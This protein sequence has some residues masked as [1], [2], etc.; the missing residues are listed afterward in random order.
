MTDIEFN[1]IVNEVVNTLKVNAKTIDQLTAKLELHPDSDWFE[2]NDGRKVSF[3]VL[4]ALIVASASDAASGLQNFLSRVVDDTANGHITFRQGLTSKSVAALERGANFGTFTSGLLGTGACINGLGDAEVNSLFSR[5]FISTPEFRFNRVAVTEG[6]LWNTNGFGEIIDVDYTNQIV[7]LKIEEG[8][9]ASIKEGDLC[10]GLYNMIGY[11]QENANRQKNYDVTQSAPDTNGFNRKPGFFTSYFWVKKLLTP[12]MAGVCKFEYETMSQQVSETDTTPHPCKNMKFAQYGNF[13]DVNRQSSMYI[14][15]LNGHSFI[16]QMEGVNTWVIGPANIA[17]RQGYLGNLTVTL[18]RADGTTYNKTLDGNGIFVKDNVYFGNALIHLDLESLEDIADRLGVYHAYLSA[19]TDVIKVDDVG[20]VIDGLWYTETIDGTSVNRYRIYTALTVRKGSELLQVAP[21]GQTLGRGYYRVT[22]IPHGCSCSFE[23]STLY[24]TGIDNVKDGVAGSSDDT[25]DAEDYAA[26]RAVERISVDLVIDCEGVGTIVQTVPVTIKHDPVPYIIADLTNENAA[27]SW[28]TNEAEYVGLPVTTKINMAKGNEDLDIEDFDINTINGVAPTWQQFIGQSNAGRKRT[29]T[30]WE[31]TMNLETGVFSV[32]DAPYDAP[33]VTEIVFTVSTHY[34]GSPYE[35]TLSLH[36]TRTADRAIWDI[37]PTHDGVNVDKNDH[38]NFSSVGVRVYSQS[39]EQGRQQAL[40]LPSGFAL[41]YAIT[42]VTSSVQNGETIYTTVTMP[43]VT[44]STLNDTVNLEDSNWRDTITNVTF[45]LYN[46]D[47]DIED[48]EGVSIVREGVGGQGSTGPAGNGVS[49]VTTYYRRS[50]LATGVTRTGTYTASQMDGDWSTA[51]V[52]PND[53]WP[54]VWSYTKYTYTKADPYYTPCVLVARYTEDGVG[55][56]DITHWYLNTSSGTGVTRPSNPLTAGWSQT[57]TPPSESLKYVWRFIDYTYSDG[58][59]AYSQCELIAIFVKDGQ[60]S[61]KS[62]VFKRYTPTTQKPKPDAPTTGSFGSPVPSGWTDGLPSG[63]EP[64]WMTSCIFTSDGK[65]PQPSPIA[66]STPV[67]MS[68]TDAFDVEFSKNAVNSFP[69]EPNG[70]NQHGGSGTQIW[71]DPKDDATEF[72]Q[73]YDEFNWM[74]TRNKRVNSSGVPEWSPWTIILIKGEPGVPGVGVQHA[75]TVVDAGVTPTIITRTGNLPVSSSPITWHSTTTNLVVGSGQCIWMS[76]RPYENGTYGEWGDPVRISGADGAAGR[77]GKDI[78][79]IYKQ[80]NE[81]PNLNGADSRPTLNNKTTAGYVPDGDGVNAGWTNN[82]SGV[83]IDHKY[84][85]MCQRVK[86]V[87]ASQWSDWSAVFVWSAYGDTGMDGDGVEYVFIRTKKKD[88]T[89][90]GISSANA[91]HNG[92][93]SSQDGYLP[94]ATRTTLQ[95]ENNQ[96]RREYTDNPKGVNSTY[97]YEWVS[98]RKQVDGVW[99][100]FSTPALWATF[101]E[102]PTVEIING[103]WWINGSNTG[104]KAE[105]EDGTGIALQGSK[106]VLYT[107]SGKT[108]LQDIDPENAELGDCWVVDANRHL[109]VFI[110]GGGEFPDYWNDMGEFKGAPGENAYVHLA[111]ANGITFEQDGFTLRS[112][113]EFSLVKGEN[114]YD[115]MGICT[116]NSPN[117]PGSE[118]WTEYEWNYVKGK[119][120]DFYDRVY[121]LTEKNV[122]PV[123]TNATSQNDTFYPTVSNRTGTYGCYPMTNTFT[124]NPNGVREAYPFEW[125]SERKKSDGVWSAFSTPVL[126]A[127][128][129]EDGE[130]GPPGVSV[131]GTV[132]YYLKTTLSSGVNTSTPGWSQTYEAPDADRPYVWRYSVNTLSNG[133]T[134]PAN[135]TCELIAVYSSS[136][137]INLLDDTS[138]TNDDAMEAWRRSDGLI[139][140]VQNDPTADPFDEENYDDETFDNFFGI[141]T[142]IQSRNAYMGRFKGTAAQSSLA[143][144]LQQKVHKSGEIEKLEGGKWYT[145]S[146][147]VKGNSQVHTSINFVDETSGL[148]MYVD[149]VQK[150]VNHYWQWKNLNNTWTRHTMTFKAIDTLVENATYYVQW[151]M[152]DTTSEQYVY[153]CMP[154]LEIG[155]VATTYT[156]GTASNKVFPRALPWKAGEMVY[157]G[158]PGERFLDMRN[159]GGSWYQCRKAHFTGD[160]STVNGSPTVDNRPGTTAGRLLWRQASEFD[161]FATQLLLAQEAYIDNLVAT[162]LRTGPIGTPHVEMEGDEIAFFGTG[163]QASIRLCVDDDGVGVL[164]FY[165]K[166]GTALYDLGPNGIVQQIDAEAS[167]YNNTYRMQITSS[168]RIYNLVSVVNN[169][170]NPLPYSY[171]TRYL[172]LV[173]GWKKIGGVKKYNISNGTSPSTWNGREFTSQP[174]DSYLA[175]ANANTYAYFIPDGWYASPLWG[176]FEE[177]GLNGTLTY[178]EV[179]QF[180]KGRD[181]TT[182]KVYFVASEVINQTHHANCY[183]ENGTAYTNVLDL[184]NA[185]I[186]I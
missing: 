164:R 155:M 156:D 116:D 113:E 67:L 47:G 82:P 16:Q 106:E 157:A 126:W 181:I 54:Y 131:T 180:S 97:P 20:N 175:S 145:F 108:A 111:W 12:Y 34:A 130:Q 105:G 183:D 153:I 9:F 137:N 2:L 70:T 152:T 94:Q 101:S 79:F 68:D 98:K 163:E 65:S 7:T 142:G 141:T 150:D 15:S 135:P 53:E 127:N 146:F 177:L 22:C 95:I 32:I 55:I 134:V 63:T 46:S 42:K 159:Y 112:Y 176:P 49:D 26:M 37:I 59:H 96:S 167:H 124:D 10:R 123:M 3:G 89:G 148:K 114:E 158:D 11:N 132:T 90:P 29:T 58:T 56:I 23:N 44:M 84:E 118:R 87:G 33:A 62:I 185:Q 184:I 24:I 18:K 76:E 1:A 48:S 27:I 138:F 100:A 182:I 66:W 165:D 13:T 119:D 86:P 75:Y 72:A 4:R 35:R 110:G 8:E 133:T 169:V 149:G 136:P 31:F 129:S 83:D 99:Q 174:S 60:S 40:T 50:T 69:A 80:S 140:K 143:Y 25:W 57:F 91:D 36:I 171:F 121:L 38:F 151:L 103:Y 39:A 128:W 73:H 45:T 170:I 154:K 64:L 19:Y 115:W 178:I 14:N 17:S 166:N 173:E 147:W 139:S 61:F 161:F 77:D 81:L 107:T 186:T 120:G 102:T 21:A 43:E 144:L 74:A 117:D 125:M 30:G 41:K 78:E 109:Y 5:E 85:W 52:A 168:T 6:E 88:S 71:F 160:G 51:F 93:T 179:H 162:T 92:K 122:T 104:V 172:Q 28:D